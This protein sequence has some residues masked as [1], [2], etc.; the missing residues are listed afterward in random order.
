LSHPSIGILAVDPRHDHKRP[1]AGRSPDLPASPERRAARGLRP[2]LPWTTAYCRGMRSGAD[3]YAVLQVPVG[4]DDTQIHSAYRAAVRR[5]HPDA[6]GSAAAFAEVQEAYEELRDPARRRAREAQRPRPRATRPPPK[7]RSAPPSSAGSGW[8]RPDPNV[9]RKAMDDL[10]AESQR[11]EDEAR[12]LAGLPPRDRGNAA[13]A[14]DGAPAAEEEDSIGA[15]LRDAAQQL[16]DM[17]DDGAREIK[18][19]LDD[20]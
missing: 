3:P 13:P 10:L 15:I 2:S 6:G 19:R 12:S 14:A 11:I 17:A 1:A 7:P 16:R 20:L 9:T 4:A 18:R 5:T 8:G